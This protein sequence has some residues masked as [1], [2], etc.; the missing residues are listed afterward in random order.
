MLCGNDGKMP[1]IYNNF[2]YRW[3]CGGCPTKDEKGICKCKNNCNAPQKYCI[4][5]QQKD[6]KII[7]YCYENRHGWSL[8]KEN[9]LLNLVCSTNAYFM[10]ILNTYPKKV[11]FDID[12]KDPN[13]LSLKMVKDIINKYFPDAKMSISGSETDEKKTYHII[14]PEIILENDEDM[15]KL[16]GL[17]KLVSENECEFFDWK[18][19]TP[20]RAFKC[21]NQSKPNK[22]IQKIMEDDN[23]KNH[24]ICSFLTGKESKLNIELPEDLPQ[25]ELNINELPKL[26]PMKLNIE[27]TKEDLND[28]KKLLNLAPIGKE[29]DHAY[30]WKVAMFCYH[31]GLS[32]DDFWEWAK[33]KEN[34]DARRTKWLNHH[35]QKIANSDYKMSKKG[36]I[37]L[38]SFYFPELNDVEN[39]G[40]YM[41]QQFLK[42]LLINDQSS[43]IDRINREHFLTNHK[44]AIFNIGMGGGKT[45]QTVEYLEDTKQSFIWLA[46]R[47]ALVMN[48]Y[49]RF[50]SKNMDVL[51]YLNCGTKK[52]DKIKN[53]NKAD[54]LIL[55]AES[56]NKIENTNKYDVLV[57]DEIET[58]LKNW[59]SETHIKNKIEDNFN[60]FI[61]LFRNCK[62]II[63]L[64]AFTT[65]ATL[66]L[67]KQLDINYIIY[68]SDF[69]TKPKKVIENF[70]YQNTINKICKELDDG[71]KLYIFHAYKSGSKKHYS[72]EELKS[73]ILEKCEKKHKI[74][75]YHGDMCDNKKKSLY[76]VNEEWD[77]YDCILTTSSITVGVNYEG[78]KYDKVYLLV[79]GFVN[80]VRDVIQTSMRIRN[81]KENIIEL[82][83]FD[84]MDKIIYKYPQYYHSIDDVNNDIYKNL[85]DN[86]LL[87]KQSNFMDSFYKFCEL[88]NYNPE[89]IKKHQYFKTE[90]FINDLYQ[91][92][93]L[94]PYNKIN[95]LTSKEVENIEI[96]NVWLNN[97]SQYQKFA[98]N[99]YYFDI[100]FEVLNDD[101][102]QYIW[103]NKL[104][105]YFSNINDPLIKMILEDNGAKNIN[106]IN[107]ND[108]KA[109]DETNKYIEDNYKI[110]IKSQNQK[111]VKILNNMLGC[112]I[113]QNEYKNKRSRY[114]ISEMGEI[115]NELNIKFEELKE[116]KIQIY[117]FL[118]I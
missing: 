19:Y 59:D 96:N 91:S 99:R 103:D 58:V 23:E 71:K 74:L 101:D 5:E 6:Q 9:E 57:I 7:K 90:K 95:K 82:Y 109:S 102:R 118:D 52:E 10:E 39:S 73:V 40:D 30:T 36:F 115:V 14:L 78:S 79:S 4:R 56:L 69:I 83:F 117:D 38:L 29:F 114:T 26:P 93:M 77:N 50:S 44:C 111:I 33:Q 81:T 86:I 13:K 16:K 116:S 12:G 108:V 27:I 51:N 34:T 80:N 65:T 106:D 31:N 21:I 97:A 45:T 110:A 3:L 41:T 70:G 89:N 25:F 98:I 18:V 84:K 64:D 2:G 47:Q 22:A 48:T 8:I 85:I 60:N 15:I 46:P 35:W 104:I 75:V 54:K 42:S 49:E 37:Q 61:K 1:K 43:K 72:I 53:I 24:F 28:N 68:S 63:L 100:K 67:L 107:Y 17:V 55:E 92:K 88:A 112:Q 113:I 32:F 94:M 20:N 105:N 11:Y 66:E 76:N 62:K 87:E